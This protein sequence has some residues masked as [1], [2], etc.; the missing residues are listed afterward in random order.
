MLIFMCIWAYC[1]QIKISQVCLDLHAHFDFKIKP[2]GNRPVDLNTS[3]FVCL[4]FTADAKYYELIMLTSSQPIIIPGSHEMVFLFAC[5]CPFICVARSHLCAHA[6]THTCPV[7]RGHTNRVKG[8][9]VAWIISR[10]QKSAVPVSHVTCSEPNARAPCTPPTAHCRCG[11]DL[12]VLPTTPRSR[13]TSY[14]QQAR[15]LVVWLRSFWM[16]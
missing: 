12:Q 4:F 6:Y 14:P 9:G 16:R 7:Q 1:F 3:D 8:S 15:R 2:R 5:F 11:D 10:V 13:P